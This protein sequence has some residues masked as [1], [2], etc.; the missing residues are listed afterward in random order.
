MF[1]GL[2]LEAEGQLRKCLRFP[3]GAAQSQLLSCQ[4]GHNSTEASGLRG[5]R[6]SAERSQLGSTTGAL[7]AL[8]ALLLKRWLSCLSLPTSPQ[9]GTSLCS[10]SV[11]VSNPSASFS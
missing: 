5:G 7:R 8:R 3:D 11:R 2:D 4:L 9:G 10:F 6:M 1:S